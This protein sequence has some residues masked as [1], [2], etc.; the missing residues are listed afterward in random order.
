M[1]VA[2]AAP[3]PCNDFNPERRP[4][5][6]EPGVVMV[7]DS[8]FSFTPAKVPPVD[9]GRKVW[10]V[11]S[12][13]IACFAGDVAFCEHALAATHLNATDHGWTGFDVVR[14]LGEL[15][16]YYWLRL[17]FARRSRPSV[18]MLGVLGRHRGLLWVLDSRGGFRGQRWSGIRVVGSGADIFL[19]AFRAIIAVSAT[20]WAQQY[21]TRERLGFVLEAIVDSRGVKRPLEENWPEPVDPLKVG[22]AVMQALDDALAATQDRSVGGLPHGEFL[23]KDGIFPVGVHRRDPSSGKW[24]KRYEPSPKTDREMRG[25]GPYGVPK[26]LADF[27]ILDPES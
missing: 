25:G 6:F 11:G 14:A 20:Q 27:T 3:L 10:S 19:P 5:W 23:T 22:G 13:A 16:R 4:L 8:R 15:L 7:T 24:S 9:V 21:Y 18:V 17:P 26:M 12:S 1:T 2:I